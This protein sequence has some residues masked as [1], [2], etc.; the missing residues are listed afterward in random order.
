MRSQDH[1]FDDTDCLLRNLR[2]G[3]ELVSN[4]SLFGSIYYILIFLCDS[5]LSLASFLPLPII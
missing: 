4:R 2:N 5:D 3:I 1:I